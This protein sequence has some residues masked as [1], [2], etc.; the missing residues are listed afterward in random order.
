[1]TLPSVHIPAL[2]NATVDVG[3]SLAGVGR[4]DIQQG[5]ATFEYEY[6]HRGALLVETTVHDQAATLA[7]TIIGTEKGAKSSELYGL[8]WFPNR[9][10]N[11]DVFIAVQNTAEQPVN[12]VAKLEGADVPFASTTL[13]PFQSAVLWTDIQKVNAAARSGS[14][15]LLHDAPE[16]A[17]HTSGWI[18]AKDIGY[19]NMMTLHDP[20]RA[21]QSKLYGTQVFLGPNASLTAS[22]QQVAVQSRLILL[23]T[24]DTP[25]TPTGIAAFTSAADVVQSSLSLPELLPGKSTMVDLRNLTL[26]AGAET[27]GSLVIDYDG[28][29]GALT[30]RIFGAA[31]DTFGFYGTLETYAAGAYSELYWTTQ[32]DMDSLLTIANFAEEPDD[33][34]VTLTYDGG[35]A[36]LPTISLQP[37]QS[38]TVDVREFRK[39]G[40]IPSAAQFGGF[41]IEGKSRHTSHLAV[42][43]HAISANNQTSAPYYGSLP[44]VYYYEYDPS[45]FQLEVGYVE[46][47]TG[48]EYF[49]D[50]HIETDHSTLYS[51]SDTSIATI[52]SYQTSVVGVGP[53]STSVYGWAYLIAD[54]FGGEDW[55]QGRTDPNIFCT[56]GLHEVSADGDTRKLKFKVTN[57][58]C[59]TGSVQIGVTTYDE[60]SLSV[61]GWSPTIPFTLELPAPSVTPDFTEFTF[62]TAGA[63]GSVN[64]EVSID[65]CNYDTCAPKIHVTPN[66]VSTGTVTVPN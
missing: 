60:D 40:K 63:P 24:S 32:G 2:G 57:S 28:P 31:N 36:A 26:P 1:M 37:L 5:S 18:E 66:N 55:F 20:T 54:Q 58:S 25:I 29:K 47:I 45:S 4:S 42:K 3:D 34:V 38:V 22:G 61:T 65:S 49:T 39:T 16:D 6:S 46:Y 14:V 7:Y 52:D 15:V 30:G 53:G 56:V 41:Q 64:I 35:T 33:V 62:T 11:A 27:T 8:Y 9:T 43:E 23:N 48:V 51:S 13:A 17:L 21:T 44:Y 50:N 10:S 12:V 59:E 19:S